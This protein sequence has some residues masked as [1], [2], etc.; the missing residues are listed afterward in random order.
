MYCV[1]VCPGMR[2]NKQEGSFEGEVARYVKLL[3]NQGSSSLLG[4]D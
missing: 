1:R 2:K 3:S 4:A